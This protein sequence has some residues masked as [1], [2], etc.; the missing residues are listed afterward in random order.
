MRGVSLPGVNDV[1]EA[2]AAL[3]AT[4]RDGGAYPTVTALAKRF[5]LNRT[6]FYRHFETQAEAMLDT[7]RLQHND[8][9]R[10]RR[11]PRDDDRDEQLRRLRQ[12]NEDLRRHLEIYEEHLRMLTVDNA[13]LRD[14]IEAAA[15]V[16][17]IGTTR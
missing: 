4:H 8:G 16:I 7:A 12:E 9:R 3:L 5:G 15:K 10:R 1:E 6:T 11:P 13:R 14:E 2:A 17:R